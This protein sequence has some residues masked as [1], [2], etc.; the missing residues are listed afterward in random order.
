MTTPAKVA[1]DAMTDQSLAFARDHRVQAEP[2]IVHLAEEAAAVIAGQ[3]P[4]QLSLAGRAVMCVAQMI[5]GLQSQFTGPEMQLLS[6]VA[7]VFALAAEQVIRE[8]TPEL[9]R[10]EED[11]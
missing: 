8:S 9:H 11:Q 3:F 2:G 6:Q 4:G 10:T 5:T 1:L 7:D